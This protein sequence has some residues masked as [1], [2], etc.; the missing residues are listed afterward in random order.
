MWNC[1]PKSALAWI[2]RQFCKEDGGATVEVIIWMPFFVILF[3]LVAE[4]ALI[5]GGKARIER[6]VQDV[7]RAVS[8]GRIRDLNEAEE[9][10]KTAIADLAPRAVVTT[11]VTDGIIR[12]QV[13]VYISDFSTLSFIDAFDDVQMAVVSQH[14]AEI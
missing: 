8:V 2:K 13:L 3:S 10:V 5:F 4:T 11:T 14:F 7:N 6:V 1:A 9:R 12:T